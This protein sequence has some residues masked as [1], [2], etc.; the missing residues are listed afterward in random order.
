[1]VLKP[2][3]VLVA[4]KLLGKGEDPW[5]YADLAD[6]LGMSPSEVHAAVK[7][8]IRAGLITPDRR[9]NRRALAEFL[10]HGL[11]YAFVGE[12]GSVTRG[13]PTAH[14]APPL[15]EHFVSGDLP[16]VWPDPE[17][18]VRG[19]AF[20]PLYPAA[21]VAARRD[22]SL[23][24]LLALVDAIRGGRARER[25]EAERQLRQRILV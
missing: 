24:E 5:T 18:A 11:K 22:P 7:R 20:S 14:A 3:D 4:L 9:A 19:E 12:R 13:M 25:K 10:V 23:Y 6:E 1:M 16:P 17:G 15:A 21:V 2:Q 8:G